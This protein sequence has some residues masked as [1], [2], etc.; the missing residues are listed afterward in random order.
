MTSPLQAREVG[1]AAADVDVRAVGLVADRVHLGAELLEG[2]RREPGV[3]AVRAV[4]ADP[5]AREVGAEALEDVLEVASSVATSRARSIRRLGAARVEQRLDLLLLRV[6]RACPP[7]SKNLTPLYSG[8]LC[9]AE[10]TTPR[11]SASSATAGVGRTPPRT[12]VPPAETIPRANASSSSGPEARVSRPTKTRPPPA[13]SVAAR[14]SRSTSSG[15]RSSPTTP[16]TPSVPKYR[17]A[18]RREATAWRTAAPCAPCAGRPSCA[19]RCA[20]HASGSPARLSGTRSS[21]FDLDERAGDAVA[22]GAGLARRAAA[23]HAHAQ[24]VL[25]LE[26]GD[27][28]RR[29]HHLA[30]DGA[31]EVLLDRPAV[32]PRL[33]VAGTQ[34]H[35][36][37]RRLALAGAEV[38]ARSRSRRAPTA[39][40]PAPRAD[41][42]ARRRS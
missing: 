42:R 6:G 8:G 1:R 34:D 30:M 21:G 29:E 4:D 2:L 39:S 17:R 14:P 11:S 36:R 31:R 10:M 27:L 24:V 16:R 20:R 33:A 18:T 19:R 38:L 5:Q 13:Q 9:D 28:E 32:D 41:A 37:D 23:V 15:V 35:A 26:P 7:P 25:S 12:A 40:A 3:R 22:D